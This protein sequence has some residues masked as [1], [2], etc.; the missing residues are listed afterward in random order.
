MSVTVDQF[1]ALDDVD[2]EVLAQLRPDPDAHWLFTRLRDGRSV[3]VDAAMVTARMSRLAEAVDPL[4]YDLIVVGTTGLVLEVAT[5]T[6]LID[7]QRVVDAWIDALTLARQSIGVVYPLERQT[8]EDRFVHGTAIRELRTG[9]LRGNDANVADAAA[10]LRDCHLVLMHSVA[11]DETT[12][13]EVARRTGR[14]VVTVRRILA[15]AVRQQLEFRARAPGWEAARVAARLEH[16]VPEL[17]QRERE[18]LSHVVEGASNKEIGRRLGI[19]YRTVEIH[20][21]RAMNKCGVASVS[22]LIRQI[23]MST[24][25]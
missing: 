2:A 8:R 16:L 11:Y 6:P 4:G 14:P 24:P 25:R 19:S 20:R 15:S 10:R 7:G 21:G 5:T 3:V 12:A 23:L 13:A 18:V 17:T 1:G 22:A 9:H